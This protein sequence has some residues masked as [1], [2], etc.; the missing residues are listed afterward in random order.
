MF[1][2]T[3]IVKLSLNNVVIRENSNYNKEDGDLDE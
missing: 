2:I 3:M 1:I